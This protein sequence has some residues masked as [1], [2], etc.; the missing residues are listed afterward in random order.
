M[1]HEEEA[2]SYGEIASS[3]EFEL[4]KSCY[5]NINQV[6]DDKQSR[7]LYIQGQEVMKYAEK[8]NKIGKIQK[9]EHQENKAVIWYNKPV[10]IRIIKN[11]I[12]DV[13][14]INVYRQMSTNTSSNSVFSSNSDLSFLSESSPSS[15]EMKVENKEGRTRQFKKGESRK[16]NRDLYSGVMDLYCKSAKPASAMS[17]KIQVNTPEARVSIN[18]IGDLQQ[19]SKSIIL[20]IDQFDCMTNSKLIL[21]SKD[22]IEVDRNTIMVSSISFI[23]S[24]NRQVIEKTLSGLCVGKESLLTSKVKDHF[25]QE[26]CRCV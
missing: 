22:E 25:R 5:Q 14:G 12:K 23:E 9:V 26:R 20:W 6:Q 21:K 11:T 19:I 4:N 13:K 17:P 7:C 1:E 16:Q 10:Y 3:I 15:S 2:N 8:L 18:I 24:P